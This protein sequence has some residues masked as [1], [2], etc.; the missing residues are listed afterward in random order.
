MNSSIN[1]D[2]TGDDFGAKSLFQINIKD[3]AS[4][5]ISQKRKNDIL[6]VLIY[7]YYYEKNT[8]NFQKGI[9]FK[10]KEKYYLIK[11]TWIKELKNYFDY[12]K[13]SKLLDTF[14]LTQDGSNIPSLDNLENNNILDRIKLYLNNS[15]INIL[16]KQPNPNLILSEIKMLPIKF[17]NIFIYYSD[18]YIINSKILEIIE[19]YMFE[20]QRKKI[21]PI[22]IFNKENNIIISLIIKNK[23][24]ATFGNLNYELIFFVNSCLVYYNLNNF[25][26]EKNYL[27]NSSFKDYIISRNCQENN[28]KAQILTKE[29]DKKFYKIGLFLKIAKVKI[30]CLKKNTDSF[31]LK[32]CKDG[33]NNQNI[34]EKY[35]L[36][37]KK[38]KNMQNNFNKYKNKNSQ[39]LSIIEQYKKKQINLME[40]N[41]NLQEEI[42]KLNVSFNVKEKEIDEKNGKIDELEKE[43]LKLKNLLNNQLKIEN[44]IEKFNITGGGNSLNNFNE[45]TKKSKEEDENINYFLLNSIKVN[46]EREYSMKNEKLKEKFEQISIKEKEINDIK[47]S[48]ENKESM[49]EE[50]SQEFIYNKNQNEILKKE[51]INLINQNRELEEKLKQKKE[52]LIQNNDNDNVNKGKKVLLSSVYQP[53]EIIDFIDNNRKQNEKKDNVNEEKKKLLS[54][55]FQSDE[56]IEFIDI[57]KQN[58]N[59]R[60]LQ[61]LNKDTQEIIST[62]LIHKEHPLQ[63]YKEPTLIGLNNIGATCYINSILQCLNQ[64]PSLTNYFL[65]D[66]NQE[67]ILN[68]N[69]IKENKNLPQLSPSYLQL[70]RMLW[71]KNRKGISF[72]PNNFLE[73]IEKMNPMF[74]NGQ[75]NDFIDFIIFI[76]EQIHRE[77]K[78]P[79]NF[80]KYSVPLN[81]YDRKNAFSN[82]M[83]GF[84]K[85]CSVISDI[86][87]GIIETTNICLYCKNFYNNIGVNYPICYNYGIF[88]CLVFPLEEVINFRNNYLAN[89]NN[90]INQNNS[91]SLNDCFFYNQKTERLTG[92]NKN[93]CN[94]CKQL[95]DSE[96]TSRIYSSPNVLILILK[97]GNDSKYNIKL[98]FYETLDLTQ[99]VEVKDRPQMIYNLYGV[100]TNVEQSWPNEH[101]I[102]FCKSPINNQWYSYNDAFVNLVEDIQKQIINFGTPIILFYQKL[103]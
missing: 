15:N 70:T 9:S 25:N 57:S 45:Q 24:F 37:Q 44:E 30:G 88:N 49:L 5:K 29:L 100:I 103:N 68:N 13:I 2:L 18:G 91:L 8:L 90:Q 36:F 39:N 85:E 38:I 63:T 69:I 54:S 77:L 46:L 65:D 31:L 42:Q 59:E 17:K 62:N 82:F 64:T 26:N 97:R 66:S 35:L 72:S 27:L 74:K 20:G 50:K 86:F 78:R 101:Y 7:I 61:N 94:I 6:I 84:Q 48:L 98:D 73:T 33:D 1:T 93:Y 52:Q 47:I 14:I 87:F 56:I 3:T 92:E 40:K 83:N 96:Y 102:G 67:M 75:K 60:Q 58:Q 71:D 43:I 12:Q 34:Q 76:I 95:Y 10:E 55:E 41:K 23:V 80:E 79:I 21:R 53:D 11:S 32:K 19:N 51:N 81:Q 4:N 22:S 16:N 99:F 28:F 89:F